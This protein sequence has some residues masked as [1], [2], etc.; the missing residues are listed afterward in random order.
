MAI[1]KQERQEW[2]KHPVTVDFFHRI[3]TTKK[4]LAEMLIDGQFSSG[5]VEETALRHAEIIGMARTISDLLQEFED[6]E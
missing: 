5:S 1:L 6:G 3:K 2:Y 4:D